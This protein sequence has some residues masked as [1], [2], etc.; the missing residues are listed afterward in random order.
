MIQIA[1]I[2]QSALSVFGIRTEEQPRYDVIDQ[3]GNVEIRRYA[4]RYA[5]ETTLRASDEAKARSDAFNILASYIFGRNTS[6]RAIAMTAPVATQTGR[7]I[8]MTAPV[9][10]VSSGPQGALIM[11]FFL[12]ANLTKAT[13]PLPDDR[14]VQ[15]V[16]IPA[17]TLAAL[18]FS[19]SWSQ[20]LI[21]Q[22]R[23]DL[24]EALQ[25]SNWL[26]VGAP[27]NLFYDPPF[28][29]PFLRRNEVAVRVQRKT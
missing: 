26:P 5:A 2:A 24:N 23:H 8:S 4:R 3:A 29:L 7:E 28:A 10:T 11:R 15:L 21:G 27:L 13:A 20:E 9:E 12:P 6:R 17:E 1:H 19:G 22:K 14:R 18:R 25:G 16:E